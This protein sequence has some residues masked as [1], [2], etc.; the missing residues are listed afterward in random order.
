MAEE[1]EIKSIRNIVSTVKDTY[2]FDFGNYAIT[3][4]KRRIERVLSVFNCKNVDELIIKIKEDKMFFESFLKEITVNTTEMFRDPSFWRK[5]REEVL[6]VIATH[7]NI[8]IWH[9]ACS[10]GE[11]VY[12]MA[13]LLKEMGLL[14]RAQI[15][16]TDINQDVIGVAKKGIYAIRN[17]ELNQ[18]NYE[19]FEGKGKLSDYFSENDGLACMDRSLIANVNFRTHDLVLGSSFSKF[20]LILCRNVLIYFNMPLQDRVVELFSNSLFKSS[21]LAVGSKETIAWCK[22]IDKYSTFSI[23]E[24]IYQKIKE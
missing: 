17:M 3:S 18:S 2:N 13:I 8:R 1:I 19:R 5:L 14:D 11:E 23:E 24:K 20:D 10:S 15:I 21:F 7:Q 9:A 16:A 6:P 22:N 4:F 12:S